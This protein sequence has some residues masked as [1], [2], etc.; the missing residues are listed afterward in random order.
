MKKKIETA[1]IAA[2]VLAVVIVGTI[3]LYTEAHAY[4]TASRGYEAIGGEALILFWPIFAY[5]AYVLIRDFRGF[6][7]EAEAIDADYIQVPD[8]AESTTKAADAAKH[9][10]EDFSALSSSTKEMS[11]AFSK[12]AKLAKTG[13]QKI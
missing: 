4:A 11:E 13:R 10:S 5:V 3:Y 9:A 1:I 6:V 2:S 12:F 7:E 8:F